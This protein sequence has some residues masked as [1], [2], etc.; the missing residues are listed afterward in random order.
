MKVTTFLGLGVV[1]LCAT[2]VLANDLPNRAQA[3]LNVTKA[4][5][6]LAPPPLASVPNEILELQRRLAAAEQ[7]IAELRKLVGT[8]G[9]KYN[10]TIPVN[11]TLAVDNHTGNVQCFSV[12]GFHYHIRAGRTEI[13]VRIGIVTTHPCRG[14]IPV[15]WDLEHWKRT[16]KGYRLAVAI[17]P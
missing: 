14:D 16:V 4:Q 2:V 17:R 3:R 1:L 13:P 10:A 15:E 5:P 12:N 11:G 7:E 6:T 9:K 8:S